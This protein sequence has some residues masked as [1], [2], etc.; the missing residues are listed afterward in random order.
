MSIATHGSFSAGL[1]AAH[2]AS[3]HKGRHKE[4]GELREKLEV[5]AASE[6]LPVAERAWSCPY[7]I[8]LVSPS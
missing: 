6:F 3:R 8:M 5:V 7:C 1:S 4:A 2:V